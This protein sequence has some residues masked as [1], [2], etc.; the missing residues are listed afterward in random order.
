MDNERRADSINAYRMREEEQVAPYDVLIHGGTVIDPAQGIHDRRDVA[1]RDGKVAAVDREIPSDQ[2]AEVINAR[3]RIVTPGLIDAHVHIYEGV[4]HYGIN[5]DATCLAHG[6]TTVVDAGS[7]G[8]DTFPGFRK[9]VIEASDTRIFAQLNI[10][11]MG[12]LSQDVGEL[13]DIKWANVPKALAMIEQNRDLILGVKVRLT[14]FLNVGKDAGLKPLF[15]AREAADA[16]GLPIMVH[17]QES[18]AESLDQVLAVMRQGDMMTHMYHGREHGILDGEGKIR[19]SVRA[20]RERGVLFDLGH[21]QGSFQWDVSE[22]ATAQEFWPTTISTDLHKYN[23]GGPVFDMAT[24]LSKF[25][26]LGMSLDDA[27]ER[28]TTVPAGVVGMPG[29]IG[30][31]KPG[32]EGDAAVFE[33]RE[34][35]FDLVDCVGQTRTGSLRLVPGAVVKAGKVVGATSSEA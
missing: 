26:Q 31:L 13:D 30:T 33:M 20:A 29:K 25:L 24:T 5:P 12:M 8:A 16:A 1:F 10:S 18:W 2:A 15:L 9:Y 28:V 21:G 23:I 11:S 17:P 6:V 32:A 35:R 4:S 7:A 3:D 14:R 27:F 22:R 19:P 34:G